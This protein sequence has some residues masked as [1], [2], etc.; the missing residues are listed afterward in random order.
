MST[1]R[2]ALFGTPTCKYCD[3]A[4]KLLTDSKISYTYQ[5]LTDV[6]PTDWRD[7][8]KY[9]RPIIGDKH[10]SIPLVFRTGNDTSTAPDLTNIDSFNG[11]TFIGSYFDLEEHLDNEDLSTDQNY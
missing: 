2:F 5:A 6:Y 9:L 3:Q 10:T 8:L 11:W 4:K 1:T 7:G